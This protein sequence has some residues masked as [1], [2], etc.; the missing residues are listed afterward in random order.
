MKRIK[1]TYS[2]K[3]KREVFN[4]IGMLFQEA[5]GDFKSSKYNNHLMRIKIKMTGKEAETF[6]LTAKQIHSI[7]FALKRSKK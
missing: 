2:A 6:N 7:E 1:I 4:A 5:D 3:K